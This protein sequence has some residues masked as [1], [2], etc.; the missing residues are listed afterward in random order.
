MSETGVLLHTKLFMPSLRP[1][2]IPRP[3]LVKKLN[4]Q[5]W[6]A[7]RFLRPLTLIS[8]PAGFGKTSLAVAWLAQLPAGLPPE[9][10]AWLSL[11]EADNDPAR[12][13]AYWLAAVQQVAPA[14]GDGLLASLPT[15]LAT[16]QPLATQL[17]NQ[18]AR[19]KQP[20]LLVLD[21]FHLITNDLVQAAIALFVEHL[22]PNT[23]LLLTSREDPPLP[24]PRLRAQR[25]LVELRQRELQFSAEETAAFLRQTMQVKLPETAVSTLNRRTEG[26]AAGLQ[27][28]ALALVSV[29]AEEEALAARLADFGGS[30]RYVLDYFMAEVLQQQPDD[31]RTFLQETA[32]LN[33]F[34]PDL[35]DAVTGRDDSADLLRQLEQANLFL[36][37]LDGR[38]RWYRYHRLFADLLRTE[39]PEAAQATIQ[40]R[41]ACW[42]AEQDFLPEAIGY[43]LAADDF[44]LAAKF[45]KQAAPAAFKQGELTTL[46]AWLAALPATQV[47]ADAELAANAGW[48]HW[49][50]G[51]GDEA[52]RYAALAAQ[53]G[54]GA[55]PR[56]LSLQA[57]LTLTQTASQTAVAQV[58]AVLDQLDASEQFFRNMVL[59]ILAEAQ[60]TQGDVAGSVATLHQAVAAGRA[61]HDP[62]MTVGATVNLAQAL[63]AQ[64]LRRE[65]ERLC[66]DLIAELQG[67]QSPPP[68]IGLALAM[69][70][71]LVYQKNELVE[72]E[73]LIQQGIMAV[74]PL[75]L[76]GA[77]ISAQLALARL[78]QAQ[79]AGAEARHIL[80]EV[81]Q[82][83]RQAR[84]DAYTPMLAAV[85][86]EL[87]LR[88][89]AVEPVERWAETAV[90]TLN[91][92]NIYQQ[93]LD[94]LVLARLRLTQ[95]QPAEAL[96]FLEQLTRRVRQTG[97]KLVQMHGALL[98]A[99]VH[100]Q[101]GQEEQAEVA[102]VTAVRLAAPENY[103]RLFLDEGERLIALLPT[104]RQVA[105]NF[106]DAVLAEFGQGHATQPLLEPLSEREL[107]V[108]R[109]VADGRS[110][111][112]IAEQ[113]FV[114][115]GTVKKHLNNVFGK[116][117]VARRTEAVAKARA[118]DLL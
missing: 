101:L 9:S 11:D 59:L 70:G 111:R 94:L 58:Q 31:R 25:Q 85:E 45:I 98:Q 68:M 1:F 36:I 22:P 20:L 96:D 114:T 72:A 51:Q 118:L 53:A 77:D 4:D 107:E 75:A 21:D 92:V 29:A 115:V 32:V 52:T 87:L 39:L 10:V 2:L 15:P 116:L 64:A 47:A 48:L 62:F 3:H 89:G 43:A 67:S 76:L 49:L 69:L 84:F 50:M 54:G 71:E 65:A 102:L 41:A 17:L 28:A 40:S 99:Q 95:S 6:L 38:R 112:E 79:G 42:L 44:D 109:L 66:R 88:Q 8:A 55:L 34:T 23:H 103:R 26:W 46:H 30:N 100:H 61:S 5:L 81:Q 78:R 14:L 56:L 35:A 105:P 33:R 91:K 37:P 60:N 90:A 18:L 73:Q 80:A 16:L 83:L 97:R 12:F 27:L 7:G 106:V 108:L 13:A 57:C 113:L 82:R 63:N 24:L 117:G 86:A 110:N 104:V 93:E 19:Q 74:E